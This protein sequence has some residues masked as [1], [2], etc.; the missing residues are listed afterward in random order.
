MADIKKFEIEKPGLLKLLELNFPA[1]IIEK[2]IGISGI[3]LNTW[4]KKL[5][6]AGE[7]KGKLPSIKQ[8][9]KSL[10][11]VYCKLEVNH[12]KSYDHLKKLSPFM[13]ENIQ[14]VLK[15]HFNID[16][17]IL[18]LDGVCDSMHYYSTIKFDEKLDDNYQTFLF[19]IYPYLSLPSSSIPFWNGQTLFKFYCQKISE[20]ILLLPDRVPEIDNYVVLLKIQIRNYILGISKQHNAPTIGVEIVPFVD[21]ALSDLKEKN[22]LVLQKYYGL[23]G[24]E[25]IS[26]KEIAKE[27]GITVTRVNQLKQQG[28]WKFKPNFDKSIFEPIVNCLSQTIKL[29]EFYEK[30]LEESERKFNDLFFKLEASYGENLS[31]FNWSDEQIR[32]FT[33]SIT[34]LEKLVDTRV[35]NALN[36]SKYKTLYEILELPV[37]ELMKIHNFGKAA[38][39][40]ITDFVSIYGFSLQMKFTEEQ[41]LYFETIV[42]I[43]RKN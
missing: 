33:K 10:F 20:N 16:G 27:S 43:K 29:K 19:D 30:Q 13:R 38:L 18:Y 3:T 15:K 14:K 35:F 7:L 25:K 37:S 32:F 39:A 1:F 34:E 2:V 8:S 4:I 41:K 6:S 9:E 22:R 31:K 23:S 26:I 21:K 28:V 5:R 36:I 12:L 40:E 11:E 24:F 17:L 42:T